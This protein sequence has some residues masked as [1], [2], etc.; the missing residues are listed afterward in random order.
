MPVPKRKTARPKKLM[1]RSHHALRPVNLT[2]CP[3]CGNKLRPH[4]VCQKCGHYRDRLVLPNA[5]E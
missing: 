1:R 2:E 3:S 4:R 5:G